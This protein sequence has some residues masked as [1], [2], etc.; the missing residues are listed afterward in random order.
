VEPTG[1]FPARPAAA[2]LEAPCDPELIRGWHNHFDNYSNYMPGYCGGL[3][4]GDCRDLDRLL[5]EGV[6]LTER[7]VLA[8]LISGDFA[9][10]LALAAGR[11]YAERKRGYLSKCH[12]C[13]DVRRHLAPG[14]EFP[15]LAP[16]EFYLHLEEGGAGGLKAGRGGCPGLPS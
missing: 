14:G 1:L 9:A 2:W 10:L 11:G 13:V 8:A 16:A 4:L 6:D 5:A 7:P 12:L 15:E 3:S